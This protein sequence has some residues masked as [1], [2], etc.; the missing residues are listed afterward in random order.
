MANLPSEEEACLTGDPVARL[1]TEVAVHQTDSVGPDEALRD[2]Q[3]RTAIHKLA[4]RARTDS[5][6]AESV[7]AGSRAAIDAETGMLP[8]EL[9]ELKRTPTERILALIEAIRV[10][11]ASQLDSLAAGGSSRPGQDPASFP[12]VG[13]TLSMTWTQQVTG[14]IASKSLSN[15]AQWTSTAQMGAGFYKNPTRLPAPNIGNITL[16]T[17]P[18]IPD[19]ATRKIATIVIVDTITHQSALKVVAKIAPNSKLTEDSAPMK[20]ETSV[21]ILDTKPR[22]VVKSTDLGLVRLEK[23]TSNLHSAPVLFAKSADSSF[24]KL[25]KNVPDLNVAPLSVAKSID[26][27]LVRLEESA[28]DVDSKTIPFAK[29]VNKDILGKP[30]RVDSAQGGVRHLFGNQPPDI[31][32][33]CCGT[34]RAWRS[35]MHGRGYGACPRCYG[36]GRNPFR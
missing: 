24:V 2:G 25:E 36:R 14:D 29:S 11:D 32:G 9:A 23:S 5:S 17:E 33:A 21:S 27:G 4:S 28:S 16:C 1:A 6:F 12:S 7:A 35:A 8:D 10:R 19:D 18:V 31:C 20:L 3:L 13:A 22:S 26:P 34:G 15:S 30:L